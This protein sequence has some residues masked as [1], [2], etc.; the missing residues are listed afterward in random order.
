MKLANSPQ[1]EA[2][3]TKVFIGN[4]I[5]KIFGQGDCVE[6]LEFQVWKFP[7]LYLIIPYSLSLGP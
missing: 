7:P 5:P 3:E 6:V 2:Q 4:I 1:N